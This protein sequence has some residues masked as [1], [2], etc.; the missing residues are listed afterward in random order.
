MIAF[1]FVALISASPSTLATKA[2]AESLPKL[3]GT[4]ETPGEKLA[5]LVLPGADR[6][7]WLGEGERVGAFVL[8]SV[9]RGR[10]SLARN[11]GTTTTV[12]LEGAQPAVAADESAAPFS[13]RWAN[14]H[15][16]PMLHH[17]TELHQRLTR[18][19]AT[20][21]ASEREALIEFYLKHGWR[22]VK[23]ES[24]AGGTL[25]IEWENIYAEERRQVVR[26]NRERFEQGLSA[27]QRALW[28]ELTRPR[29]R[30]RID[31]Q[32]SDE[33]RRELAQKEELSARFRALLSPGQEAERATIEDFTKGKW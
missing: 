28:N 3:Y 7:V 2:P 20:M 16:N 26:E 10:I 13:R 27:E 30:Q 23:V 22:M 8:K 11:D 1:I 5:S 24:Y 33:Q 32:V 17:P 6:G 29:E 19:W 18:A 15:D 4:V 9:E 21:T 31:Q 12:Y 14:S 25:S